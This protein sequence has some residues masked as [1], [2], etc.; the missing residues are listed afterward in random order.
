MNAEFTWNARQQ[1]SLRLRHVSN[2]NDCT[3]KK[4]IEKK[5]KDGWLNMADF[6][7]STT[8]DNQL[9]KM[10]ISLP[11]QT[12]RGPHQGVPSIFVRLQ[13][14]TSFHVDKKKE[15]PTLFDFEKNKYLIRYFF[16][17]T[18]LGTPNIRVS[19]YTRR[20][21]NT[22]WRLAAIRATLET[23]STILGTVPIWVRSL[24]TIGKEREKKGKQLSLVLLIGRK[25]KKR[26]KDTNTKWKSDS[27]YKRDNDR[28][29][30]NCASMLKGGWWWKSCGRGLNGIYLTDP[31]DL[32]ARQGIINYLNFFFFFNFNVR[33]LFSAG[34][35]WFRWRG[36][37]YTLKRATMMIRP[38]HYG[39]EPSINN[40]QEKTAS[41]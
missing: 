17:F 21:N 38:R 7:S 8:T 31:Q 32:T 15:N 20:G 6:H 11:K 3:K 24:R 37:D 12:A 30:L 13:E 22:S 40:P 28:S 10:L 9:V 14:T 16:F 41:A 19:N 1:L 2:I 33:V 4:E 39:K 27:K 34:I 5:K 26:K 25:K 35:V 18:C 36:W 29:S 23:R